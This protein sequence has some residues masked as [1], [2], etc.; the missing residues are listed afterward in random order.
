MPLSTKQ[1][2][3]RSQLTRTFV[4]GVS[5]LAFSS[6][7]AI[8]FWSAKSLRERVLEGSFNTARTL[9]SQSALAMTYRSPELA[10]DVAGVFLSYPDVSGVTIVLKDGELLMQA[11]EKPEHAMPNPIALSEPRVV[12]EQDDYWLIAA[13]TYLGEPEDELSQTQAYAATE[14]EFL[15]NVVLVVEKRGVQQFI[16]QTVRANFVV[17]GIVAVLVVLVLLRDARR[18]IDPVDQLAEVMRRAADGDE[19]VRADVSGPR[20]IQEMQSVFNKMLAVQRR[21]NAELAE[22]VAERTAELERANEQL[23]ASKEA[24]EEARERADQA[25]AAKSRFLSNMSHELRTP[26][27]AIIGYSEM[28]IE[29][30]QT[31]GFEDASADLQKVRNSGQHLLSLINEILDLARIESGRVELQLEDI[32]LR[33]LFQEVSAMIVPMAAKYDVSYETNIELEDGVELHVDALRTKEILLNLISNAVKYGRDEQGYG[34]VSLSALDD[35]VN[36]MFLVADKGSGLS[37]AQVEEIWKPFSRLEGTSAIEGTGIGL[38]LTKRLV[39]VMGGAIGVKSQPGAGSTF[40]V[41]L[42][43]ARDVGPSEWAQRA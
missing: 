15:G 10:R 11:G 40:W 16:E 36:V 41:S 32:P 6:S 2:T 29:E 34:F 17:A 1:R 13:S 31:A 20:E 19:H 24:A 18:I 30:S 7:A 26:L 9:A 27:N 21:W 28:L 42:P 4:L 22:R 43:K 8:S 39:E 38:A 35:G 12:G 23:H 14:P 5:L 3:I 33:A 25:N 37:E